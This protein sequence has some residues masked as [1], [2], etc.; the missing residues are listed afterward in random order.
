MRKFTEDEEV[1]SSKDKI[2]LSSLKNALGN[3]LIHFYT[4]SGKTLKELGVILKMD[5]TQ[6]SKIITRYAN[7]PRD[8]Y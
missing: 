8:C 7:P 2:Y 1:K 4:S 5:R 3:S 6:L